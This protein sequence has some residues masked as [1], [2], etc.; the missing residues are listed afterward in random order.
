[1]NIIRKSMFFIGTIKNITKHNQYIIIKEDGEQYTLMKGTE[2]CLKGRYVFGYSD[3]IMSINDDT[4][5]I[6]YKDPQTQIYKAKVGGIE[7]HPIS[8][9]LRLIRDG[10]MTLII[11]NK[12]VNMPVERNYLYL[13]DRYIISKDGSRYQRYYKDCLNQVATIACINIPE[14]LL[15]LKAN[16]IFGWDDIFIIVTG[17]FDYNSHIIQYTAVDTTLLDIMWTY[18]GKTECVRKMKRFLVTEDVILDINTGEV[19]YQTQKRIKAVGYSD[20]MSHY[21]LEVERSNGH[22]VMEL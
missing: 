10:I 20:D 8:C 7:L 18:S 5:T 16:C 4:L 2:Q 19:V 9:G 15:N 14:Y 12:T 3:Y 13:W 22:W 17:S 6:H 21:V 1:M 11:V